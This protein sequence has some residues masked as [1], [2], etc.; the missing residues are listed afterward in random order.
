MEWKREWKM[1]TELNGV[2]KTGR[3][4]MYESRNDILQNDKKCPCLKS[5]KTYFHH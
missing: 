3:L 2:K 5:N 4:G 1:R